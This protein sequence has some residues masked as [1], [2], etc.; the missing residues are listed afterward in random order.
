[1]TEPAAPLDDITAALTTL[2]NSDGPGAAKMAADLTRSAWNAAAEAPAVYR[3][4]VA[5]AILADSARKLRQQ[6]EVMH[7]EADCLAAIA[8]VFGHAF[9][10]GLTLATVQVPDYPP[11]Q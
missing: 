1:M 5:A 2:R 3:P 6:G 8:G 10:N 7:P 11:G 4:A 9:R